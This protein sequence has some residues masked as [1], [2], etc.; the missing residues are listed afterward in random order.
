MVN[1]DSMDS[2]INVAC[3]YLYVSKCDVDVIHH[4][5]KSLLFDDSHTWIKKHGGWF[6]VSMSAY[7]GAEAYGFMATHIY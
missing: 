2:G 4:T 5:R 7:D 3:E 1:L 6:D